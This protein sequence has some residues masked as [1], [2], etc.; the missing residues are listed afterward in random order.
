MP[1]RIDVGGVSVSNPGRVLFKAA[2]IT[3]LD[4]A[5]YYERIAPWIVPHVKGRPLTLVRCPEGASDEC[6][7]MKHSKVWAPPQLRRIHIREKKKIGDYLIAD[8]ADALIAL[9]QMNVL[10]IHTWNSTVDHLE[11]P[12]RIV[13]DIDPGEAV[14][15]SGVA[16][17]ARTMRELLDAL[18]L[19]SFPKTTGGRG[20]HIV[21]PLA[22]VH[23]WRDCLE[24]A[25]AIAVTMT[26]LEPGRYTT[27]FAKAGREQKILI[28]Y[29]RNNRTNTSV[30]AFSTRAKPHAP[31][32]TPI[33]W[34][35]LTPRLRPDRFTIGTIERRLGR[36]TRDPW[37]EY[38]RLRQRFSR[39]TIEALTRL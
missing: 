39:R 14:S 15:W 27:A 35:E 34:D 28:D 16:Q 25:R 30:A 20:I 10:E 21:V 32:S 37:A 7:Y 1:P 19:R 23:N 29:L 33:R 24:L 38:W 8:D 36:L 22:P 6:F 17:A 11:H 26:R 9:V 31:I 3:K 12:D 5:R 2:A 13:L 4:L 18:R